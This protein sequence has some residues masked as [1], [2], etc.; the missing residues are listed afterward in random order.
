MGEIFELYRTPVF[1]M[2]V[3]RVRDRDIALDITQETFI[4]GFRAIGKFSG[5]AS[6]LTWLCQ[7]AINLTIDHH[8]RGKRRPVRLDEFL[9][10]GN[11]ERSTGAVPMD[12][13]GPGPST[14]PDPVGEA[15]G[16]ELRE[17]LEEALEQLSEKH[18]EIFILNAFQGLSYKEM[19]ETLGISIGTVMSRLFY[20]RK[21]L[22]SIL[23]AFKPA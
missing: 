2:A 3:S 4:K 10:P 22:Q 9:R 15:S 8:R 18:R 1:R 7:I 19:A 21:K 23:G 6:L 13:R 14:S 11:Q 17:R 16:R 12:E 20:A 5:R